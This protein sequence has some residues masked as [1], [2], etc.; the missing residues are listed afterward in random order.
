MG[1]FDRLMGMEK[2]AQSKDPV[3]QKKDIRNDGTVYEIYLVQD[4]ES[5][6]QFLSRQKVTKSRLCRNPQ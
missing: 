5:A 3:F 4:P 2:S 6:K 1:L